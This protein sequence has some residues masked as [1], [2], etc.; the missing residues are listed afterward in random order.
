LQ[1]AQ[2][3][4]SSS[5][6]RRESAPEMGAAHPGARLRSQLCTGAMH[7]TSASAQSKPLSSSVVAQTAWAVRVA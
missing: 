3:R 1:P 7:G 6:Q 5:S 4:T 2:A